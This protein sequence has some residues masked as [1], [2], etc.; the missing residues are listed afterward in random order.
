MKINSK[1]NYSIYTSGV[2]QI[3]P[4]CKHKMIKLLEQ[5]IGGNLSV[6]GFGDF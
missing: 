3:T 2:I 4:Q 1:L 5:N 6:V